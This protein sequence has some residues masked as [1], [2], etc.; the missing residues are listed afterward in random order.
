MAD[1]FY[2]RAKVQDPILYLLQDIW[3]AIND[4]GLFKVRRRYEFQVASGPSFQFFRNRLVEN[5]GYQHS[6]VLRSYTYFRIKII[7]LVP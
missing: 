1:I 7:V 2:L 4:K 3:F 6:F 5:N